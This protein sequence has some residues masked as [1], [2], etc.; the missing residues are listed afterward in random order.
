MGTSNFHSVSGKI[1]AIS[2]EFF[3]S[4]F[5]DYTDMVA[6]LDWHLQAIDWY[7]SDIWWHDSHKLRSYPSKK[8][9]DICL[10]KTYWDWVEFIAR[11]SIVSRAWYY[12]G[13]NIDYHRE[14]FY[15]SWEFQDDI[16]TEH[17]RGRLSSEPSK[18]QFEYYLKL[19]NKYL[20]KNQS[21]IEG[22]VDKILTTICSYNLEIVARFS[23][24]ET[25]Y[26]AI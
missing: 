15:Y 23:N 4:H 7:D 20:E 21:I 12:E 14:Y 6:Y 8:I 17:N 22:K 26:R 13:C 19:W 5:G 2:E 25:M 10:S 9:W 24:W 16:I 11:L 18:K 3:D 1:Y